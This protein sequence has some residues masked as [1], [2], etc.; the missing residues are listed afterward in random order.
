MLNAL[1]QTAVTCYLKLPAVVTKTCMYAAVC[2][3][4]KHLQPRI[5]DC[6]IHSE[7]YLSIRQWH[8]RVGI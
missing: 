8:Q 6:A 1:P 7:V 5:H 2:N 4:R 3:Y